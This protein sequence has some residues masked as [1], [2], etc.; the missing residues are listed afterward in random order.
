[1]GRGLSEI[2]CQAR[3]QRI[4]RL[5]IEMGTR[6]TIIFCV[7]GLITMFEAWDLKWPIQKENSHFIIANFN[8]SPWFPSSCELYSWNSCAE[9]PRRAVNDSS[10]I[11]A[12]YHMTQA[13]NETMTQESWALERCL[14]IKRHVWMVHPSVILETLNQ[15]QNKPNSVLQVRGLGSCWLVLVGEGIMKRP[16]F[17]QPSSD[18]SKSAWIPTVLSP[19]GQLV[20]V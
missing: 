6:D 13:G 11:S 18:S 2:R 1:M 3:T 17:S 10:L 14:W 20:F 8:W 5:N 4:Q 9:Q 16:F 15:L 12:L 19:W 7:L